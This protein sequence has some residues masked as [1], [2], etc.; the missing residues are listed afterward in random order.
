MTI[1]ANM[2]SG[3]KIININ[4][5]LT[6]LYNL[7]ANNGWKISNIDTNSSSDNI[8][9][10]KEGNETEFFEISLV[11]N[12]IY[13]SVPLKNSSFQYKAKFADY[14]SAIKYIENKFNYFI[15]NENI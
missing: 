9:Y 4:D 13:V 10:Y 6:L 1:T 7:F 14:Y 12:I 5:E 15:N 8:T 2:L 3:N 11:D